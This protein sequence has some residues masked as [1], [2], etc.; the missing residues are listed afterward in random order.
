VE[1]VLEKIA[2]PNEFILDPS[3]VL[4]IPLHK[5]D[6]ASFMSDDAYGHLCTVTGA[7]WTPQGRTFDGDDS[8]NC[9][10]GASLNNLTAVTVEAWVNGSGG[11][12]IDKGLWDFGPYGLNQTGL[13]G[14]R[15]QTGN[16][17]GS[18]TNFDVTMAAGW[19]HIVEVAVSNDNLYGYIDGALI[20]SKAVAYAIGGWGYNLKLGVR[21]DVAGNYYN[22][23]IGEVRVYNR[24]LTPLEI[25]HNYLATKWRYR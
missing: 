23:T 15:F 2:S 25:Q 3:C 24:A 8:I 1:Q 20:N 16:G 21:A 14:M 5:R 13:T 4:Y 6:G 10:N 18:Y 11:V 9:W 22:G 19:R 12:I 7:P 17:A